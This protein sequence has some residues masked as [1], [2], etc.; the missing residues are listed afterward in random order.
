MAKV[1]NYQTFSQ[2][3]YCISQYYLEPVYA[4]LRGGMV[5]IGPNGEEKQLRMDNAFFE[6][7]ASAMAGLIGHMQANYGGVVPFLQEAG[8]TRDVMDAIRK[9]WVAR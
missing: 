9:K 4:R 1:N 7:P 8:V 6:T 5:K 2:V 3:D